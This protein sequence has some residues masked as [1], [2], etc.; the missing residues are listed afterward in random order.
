M[1][2]YREELSGWSDNARL[3]GPQRVYS[4]KIGCVAHFRL[5]VL[6]AS[7]DPRRANQPITREERAAGEGSWRTNPV[8]IQGDATSLR[9]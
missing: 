2:Q 9:E 4:C 7:L 8:V 6:R 5:E 1:I 3:T